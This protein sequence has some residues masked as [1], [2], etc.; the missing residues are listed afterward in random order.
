MSLPVKK[1]LAVDPREL[2][3][4]AAYLFRLS[5]FVDWPAEK[6][7]PAGFDNIRFCIADGKETAET[8]KNVL[9]GKTINR[10]AIETVEVKPKAELKSCHLLYITKNTKAED[11][12]LQTVSDYPVLTVGET[13]EFYS[14]GGMVLLFEKANRIFFAINRQAADR[15]RVKFGAQLL[16]LAEQYP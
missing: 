4:K 12:L 3:I 16:N 2:T 1:C 13:G 14:Q 15:A 11:L 6:L 7:S 8:I 9:A 5:L 10:H